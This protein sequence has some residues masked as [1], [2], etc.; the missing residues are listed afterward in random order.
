MHPQEI[1]WIYN[2]QYACGLLS[3]QA[4]DKERICAI[5][6]ILRTTE[7]SSRLSVW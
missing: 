5:R 2:I 3:D 4:F 7:S 6:I 1:E